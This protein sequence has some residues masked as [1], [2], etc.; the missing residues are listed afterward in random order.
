GD[1][2]NICLISL[3]CDHRSLPFFPT[4]RSSDLVTFRCP[5]SVFSFF[6]PASWAMSLVSSFMLCAFACETTPVTVTL[7]PTCSASDRSGLRSEEHTSELQS[8]DHLV[9]RLL[10][11]N[12]N[13]NE[14]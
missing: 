8:P 14:T 12:K 4:R 10:L 3:Y 6:M 11:D 13:N 7:C 2:C 5:C 9:C 1:A